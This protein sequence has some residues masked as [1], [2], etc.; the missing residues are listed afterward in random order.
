MVLVINHS[1][2]HTCLLLKFSDGGEHPMHLHGH[3]FWV[4]ATSDYPEAETLYNGYYLMRDIVSVPAQGW[5]KIRFVGD[6]PGVWPFHCH[7]DWHMALG[8]FTNIIE[9]LVIN[10]QNKTKR[11][12]S[13]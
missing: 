9:E 2:F 13:I 3:N 12:N 8:L 10:K 7:I 4:V 5:A 11:T 1:L 6:N